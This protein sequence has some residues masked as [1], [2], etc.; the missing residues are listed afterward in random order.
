MSPLGR[1]AE[2]PDAFFVFP[3][4]AANPRLYSRGKPERLTELVTRAGSSAPG[5]SDWDAHAAKSAQIIIIINTAILAA[6][7]GLLN[8]IA[9]VHLGMETAQ[10]NACLCAG[11]KRLPT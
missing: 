11:F 7:T 2:S 3:Q 8:S 6:K 1:R 5:R 9:F 4:P 10:Q